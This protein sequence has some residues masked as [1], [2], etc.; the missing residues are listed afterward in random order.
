VSD[1]RWVLV[2]G[3]T[4]EAGHWGDFPRR[5]AAATGLPVE[6]PDLPGCGTRH[7]E[8]APASVAG[9]LAALRPAVVGEGPLWL[10]GLSLGGMV[11]HEWLRDRPGELGGAVIVNSSLGGLSSPW[12][13]MRPAAAAG[14][15][16]AA[17][18]GDELSRERLVFSLTSA[19]ADLSVVPAWARLAV[20]R[21][22]GRLTALRQIWAAARY[23]PPAPPS[24]PPVLVLTSDGDRLVDAR[25]SRALAARTPGAQLRVHPTAGHDLPLDAPDWI[26]E[27]VVAWRRGAETQM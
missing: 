7:R 5:L 4:R 22:V 23:R 1:G 3:L 25:C 15:V 26:L 16:K 2:R 18:T 13:R 21:P 12:R 8:S 17:L 10:F 14:V 27:E 6:T 20:E 24:P 19:G 9:L 11:V